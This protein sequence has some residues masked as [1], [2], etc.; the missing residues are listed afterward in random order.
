MSVRKRKL[1]SGEA[2]W[3]VDYRDQG[4]KRRHKQF[5]T[6][7]EATNYETTVRGEL[8]AGTHVAD[9]ASITVEQAG[10]LWLLRAEREGLEASTIRQ[11]RQHLSHHIV[12]LIGSSK[13][14][15]LKKPAVEEFRDRLVET[16]SRALARA[17]LTSLKGILKEASRRGLVAQNAASETAVARSRRG[18]SKVEIPTKEEIR[19]LLTKSA[20]LWSITRVEITRQQGRKII[21][22]PWR[23][24]IITAIFTGLRCSELRGLGWEHVDFGD[25]VILVRRR[26]DF[27]NALG[28]PKTEAGTRDVPMSPMVLNTLKTWR[29]A[30]PATP[31]DIVFPTENGAIHSTPN[32]HKTC[33]RPLLRAVGLVD[34][35]Q[36]E[37]GNPT[38]EP[39]YTFHALRHAAASLFIEQGWS[40]KKVQAVMGHA[41]I[42]VTFDTYGHLW[43]TTDDDAKAMAQIEKRLM[44]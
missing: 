42:Q 34:I 38:E 24:L 2:R 26:A 16:R 3:Q 5:L 23:P 39:H 36:D 21:A 1:P 40:P 41:S 18:G 37:E 12:P 20:E 33:W 14:T 43:K 11:Y 29:L 10:D 27:Q 9:S 15:R 4:G 13:L 17:V 30:C 22:V 31:Q 7:A 6:K 28:P 44:G 25:K 8:M 32:I 35:G 19:S